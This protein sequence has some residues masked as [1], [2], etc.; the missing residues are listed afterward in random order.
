ME[1]IGAEVAVSYTYLAHGSGT[2]RPLPP[3][4]LWI[5]SNILESGQRAAAQLDARYNN[6]S[7]ACGTLP[8]YYCAG[9]ILRTVDVGPF[10]SWNPSPDAKRLG[11]VSF[12][13]L[14]RD[15]GMRDLPGAR[16]QGIIF[17]DTN[18][19]NA[20]GD[21]Y[22]RVL[23][24]YPT[25][26]G[27][28]GRANQGCGRNVTWPQSAY[29]STQGV[30]TVAKWRAHYY[31]VAGT[32]PDYNARN[33]HQ[34]SFQ[35]SNTAAF[36]V[37]LDARSNFTP[38]ARE[39]EQHNELVLQLWGDNLHGTL[40]LEAVFYDVQRNAAAGL[41]NARVI[42]R[43]YF[44]CTGSVLPIMRLFLGDGAASAFSFAAA[45]QGVTATDVPDQAACRAKESW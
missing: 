18:S 41:V 42:Q 33:D 6:L 10:L 4:R 20:A 1:N 26:A 15:L 22:V 43:D 5:T 39:R 27:T 36:A 8:A 7:S 9:V 38:P 34:C 19:A 11:A 29:C 32:P 3:L 37:S 2:E 13:F 44:N 17:K 45:D 24:A 12:S 14:R 25:D 35:G 23:C 21:L 28:V 40:P 16:P 30:D 31:A